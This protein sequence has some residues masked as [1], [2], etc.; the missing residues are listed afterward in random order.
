MA[1][2]QNDR[3]VLLQAATTRVIPI[4][5]PIS[6]VE[7]LETELDNINTNITNQGT[8]ITSVMNNTKDLSILASRTV[9]SGSS[10]T[11]TLTAVFKNGLTGTAT[12]SVTAGSATLVPNGNTCTVSGNTVSGSAVT[13]RATVTVSGINYEA[14]VTLSKLGALSAQ[15]SVDLNTQ[16]TGQLA[17]GKITG[18]GALA[19]LN[20]VDLSTQ[21]VGALNGQ[22]QVTNLGTLAYANSI[23]A[24]QIGAGTLAAGV[25]YAGTVNVDKLVGTTIVGKNIEGGH[26]ISLSG[27]NGSTPIYM[28]TYASETSAEFV[29]NGR[30]QVNNP[31]INLPS[32]VIDAN[33]DISTGIVAYGVRTK[34][35]IS[36]DFFVRSN[37]SGFDSIA[38][39]SNYVSLRNDNIVTQTNDG[40]Y[41]LTINPA[42]V[43]IQTNYL[44]IKPLSSDPGGSINGDLAIIGSELVVNIGGTRYKLT[45][46]PL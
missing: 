11:I 12:W 28:V 19:L 37:G 30:L 33:G 46:T 17:T 8:L 45:K 15:D 43:S 26:I 41:T 40:T 32:F 21:T 2:I 29:C 3:D 10:E 44:N 25:I 14:F 42:R 13:I 34:M 27:A 39:I 35:S 38:S 6:Q 20:A 7:G 18:L 5:I 24:D 16:V 36:G 22:T 9:F 4:P 31:N 23:A 1:T